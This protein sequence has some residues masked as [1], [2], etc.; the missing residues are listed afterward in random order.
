MRV[1]FK[2][3]EIMDPEKEKARRE[4]RKK[5]DE[6]PLEDVKKE[7]TQEDIWGMFF[8]SNNKSYIYLVER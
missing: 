1:A 3:I 5:K 2:V 8:F 7:K 6:V 4:R